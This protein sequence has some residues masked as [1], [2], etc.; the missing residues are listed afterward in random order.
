MSQKTIQ[1]LFSDYMD[2]EPIFSN[3]KALT[4]S[5]TPEDVPHRDNQ[6][7]QLGLIL[8][9]ALKNDRPSNVFI[10]GSTGTGKTLI[11]TYVTNQLKIAAKKAESD[12]YIMY[13][14]CKMKRVADTEY[15][16]LAHLA[17]ILEKEVPA[18][19]L[20]TDHVYKIFFDALEER[21]GVVII[22]IDEI[23]ALISKVGDELLY[24][25]TRINQELQNIK[26][27]IIGISNNLSFTDYI[28]ARVKS[29]LSEEELV[30]PPYNAVQLQDILF[31]R[32]KIAFSED[33]IKDGVLSKCAAL[34][35]Q[36]HG[37]ARRALDL[38]RV[39]G[40]L[41]E[42]NNNTQ[43]TEKH[44]DMAESKVDMDRIMEV[45]KTQPKQ[46]KAVICSIF[47]LLDGISKEKI[48]TGEVYDTYKNIC[49]Q[50]S[51]K[52]L[53]QR[54]IS[55]IITELDMLSIISAKVISKGRY[56][57]TREIGIAISKDIHSRIMD[58]LKKEF[59]L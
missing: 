51:L 34:A 10:Y 7:N 6:I 16:L 53:T 12:L 30:F 36:E 1:D 25:L 20:P 11:T 3:K 15:R 52:P 13:V 47:T 45:V 4:I 37:D 55:D 28:D 54:R 49:S 33:K 17:N 57:R 42:R 26:I 9:P 24:N 29:A 50:I 58:Y 40:E 23:D 48:L 14:N 43:I 44:V 18:T 2:K 56:G 19:G 32:A 22:I 41:A 59:Y 46:S 35:A 31:N 21:K 8:A 39:A 38:L 5:Y 27:S